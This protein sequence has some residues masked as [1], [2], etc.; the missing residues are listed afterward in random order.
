MNIIGIDVSKDILVGARV[1]RSCKQVE[2]Y[3]IGNTTSEIEQLITNLKDCH[4][5][6]VIACESTV[7]YH[8]DLTLTCLKEAIPFRLINPITTKQFV[9][10]TVRGKKL[11]WAMHKLL[12]N[13]F[14]REK[15]GM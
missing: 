15:E 9:K 11:T 6:V 7:D 10:V 1:N 4:K 14:F 2:S 8:R 3:H 5:K 12:Q 13:L